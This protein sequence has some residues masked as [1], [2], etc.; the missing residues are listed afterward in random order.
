MLKTSLLFG[1]ATMSLLAQPGPPIVSPEVQPDHRVTFR[2]QAP[3]AKQVFLLREGTEKAA[4]TKNDQGIW[5][6]T[7][8]PLEPDRYSYTFQVDGVSLMDPHNPLITPNLLGSASAVR[9][10]GTPPQIWEVADVPRGVVHHHFY[11]SG[12][13]GDQRDYY[14]YTPPAYSS[15]AKPYPVL[16]LLHGFSDAA[17]GWTAVGEANVILDNLIAAGKVKPM[18]VVMPLG[19]GAPEVLAAGWRRV[20]SDASLWQRNKT[21]FRDALLAEVM[22]QVEQQYRVSKDRKLH[23]ITGLSMGG[24]ESVLT[25]LNALDRFA[26]VGSFSAGGLDEDF[27]AAYPKLDAKANAQLKLLWIACGVDDGLIKDNRKFR[28]WL[29][30]KEVKL[31]FVETPGAHTW[32]VWRRNLAV[33]TQLLFQGT[34]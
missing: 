5:S 8:P 2:F 30:S 32:M 21:R 13:V 27:N 3:N 12:I 16:Y 34:K 14:V 4:M 20:G 9:V 19:Y 11:K 23:A 7:T 25:G 29:Q 28:D 6:V 18:V 10:P 1:I 26:W 33:F 22:P 31:T 15:K 24:A 17:N